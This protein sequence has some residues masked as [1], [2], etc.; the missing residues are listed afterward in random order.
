MKY[1]LDTENIIN[2]YFEAV[3]QIHI[4]FWKAGISTQLCLFIEGI[5]HDMHFFKF[6]LVASSS[7][8]AFSIPGSYVMI[9]AA[10]WVDHD[11]STVGLCLRWR[12]IFIGM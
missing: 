11:L 1:V 5:P 7:S 9:T 10:Q 8:G 3:E 4:L 6:L 12:P 2:P